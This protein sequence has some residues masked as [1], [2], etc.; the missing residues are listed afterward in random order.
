MP[1]CHPS[2]NNLEKLLD[3]SWYQLG[4]H[5]LVVPPLPCFPVHNPSILVRGLLTFSRRGLLIGVRGDQVG[6]QQLG[7]YLWRM[8]ADIIATS[9]ST[10]YYGGSVHSNPFSKICLVRCSS[11]IRRERQRASPRDYLLSCGWKLWL[12]QG[13]QIPIST[14]ANKV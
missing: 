3:Q 8:S 14:S 4:G 2:N 10:S 1:D 6:N 13:Q 5:S 11:T 12:G 9:A 7:I